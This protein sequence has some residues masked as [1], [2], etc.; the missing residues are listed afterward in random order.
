MRKFLACQRTKTVAEY[1]KQLEASG[2]L[3]HLRGLLE[4]GSFLARSIAHG[5][6]CVVHCSDGW[7]RTAQTV[8]IAQLLLDSFYRTIRGFQVYTTPFQMSFFN[9]RCR[10]FIRLLSCIAFISKLICMR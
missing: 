2:W 7:D 4:C 3:R 9:E 1:Y 10:I 6:S 5:I 8:S